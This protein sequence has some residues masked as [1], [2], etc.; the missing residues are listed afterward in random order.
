MI[1]LVGSPA[2]CEIQIQDILAVEDLREDTFTR[3]YVRVD[4]YNPI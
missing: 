4:D 2:L 3:K 1:L